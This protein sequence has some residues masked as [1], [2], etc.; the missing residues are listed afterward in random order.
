[1]V[2]DAMAKVAIARKENAYRSATRAQ[3][4]PDEAGS[5]TLGWL[6]ASAIYDGKRLPRLYKLVDPATNRT[7]AYVRP[8]PVINATSQLGRLVTIEGRTG[9]DVDLKVRLIDAT[10]ARLVRTASP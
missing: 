6:R 2:I 7:I 3:P 1:M 5:T 9:F 4:G 10:E 8:G